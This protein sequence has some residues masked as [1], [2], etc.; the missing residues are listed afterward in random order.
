M[1]ERETH[2][3]AASIA[4]GEKK[5]EREKGKNA[6]PVI[7]DPLF[8]FTRHFTHS[9]DKGKKKAFYAAS[10]VRAETEIQ[11][12]R[13]RERETGERRVMIQAVEIDKWPQGEM[14]MYNLTRYSR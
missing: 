9:S 7:R 1:K 4:I 11:G 5:G 14:G 13:K 8:F 10:R 3:G 6:M 12:K 2:T